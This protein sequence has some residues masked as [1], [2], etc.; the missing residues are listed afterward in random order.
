VREFVCAKWLLVR[1][2]VGLGV[3][4]VERREIHLGS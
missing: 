2:E 1:D 3:E 4:L